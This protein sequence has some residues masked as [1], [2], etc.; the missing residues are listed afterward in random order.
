MMCDVVCVFVL[1]V[2]VLCVCVGV[3]LCIVVVVLLNGCVND[4]LLG[5]E[6]VVDFVW[7]NEEEVYDDDFLVYMG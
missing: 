5:C 3:L 7:V 2:F 4:G 6:C 1:C